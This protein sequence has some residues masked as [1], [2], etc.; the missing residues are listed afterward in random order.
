VVN[1]LFEQAKKLSSTAQDLNSEMK[2]VKW[3]LLLNCYP[4]WMIKNKKKKQNNVLCLYLKSFYRA[5]LT[6]E[7]L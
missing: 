6:W 4:V 2:Y 7:S 5:Q 1:I 3:T